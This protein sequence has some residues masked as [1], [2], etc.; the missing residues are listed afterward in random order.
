[1]SMDEIGQELHSYTQRQAAA[2]VR[3]NPYQQADLESMTAGL[4]KA[5]TGMEAGTEF[6]E[7][8]PALGQD[9]LSL[10]GKAMVAAAD[11]PTRIHNIGLDPSSPGYVPLLAGRPTVKIPQGLVDLAPSIAPTIDPE[12]VQGLAQAGK[13]TVESMVP[14][15]APPEV[16][17]T[18][19]LLGGPGAVGK[20]AGTLFGAE[21]L[22][23]VP[24][25]IQQAFAVLMDPNSSRA[26]KAKALAT[27][28]IH[29]ALGALMLRGGM[30]GVRPDAS[31]IREGA[32]QVR[33]AGDVP[34]G[35]Q[36]EGGQE[37]L[38]SPSRSGEQGAPQGE[39][40]PT[41]AALE[42]RARRVWVSSGGAFKRRA[43]KLGADDPIP[44]WED[45]S[46]EQKNAAR[47]AMGMQ[48]A[49]PQAQAATPSEQLA[50][51]TM[52]EVGAKG[53][54]VESDLDPNNA[55]F[56]GQIS[57]ITPDGRIIINRTEFAKW[58]EGIPQAQHAEAI[59]SLIDEEHIHTKTPNAEALD[60]WNSLSALE[61]GLVRRR[62][63]GRW[64]AGR[65]TDS[66]LGHEALRGRLQQ[67]SG[68][69]PREVAEAA[70]RERWTVKGIYAA[71]R[72]IA[73][74]R[75]AL[76]T[77]AS[78]RQTE[79]I[80]RIQG[81]LAVARQSIGAAPEAFRKGSEPKPEDYGD[82]DIRLT[83]F[84][85]GDE[86]VPDIVQAD[87]I[88]GGQNEWSSNPEQLRALGFDIPD[89]SQLPAGRYTLEEAR[90][91]LEQPEAY[92]KKAR[93]Q[94]RGQEMMSLPV[95][96]P[97]EERPGAREAIAQTSPPLTAARI[98]E[99][100][101][102][103]FAESA[104]PNF[105]EF[106][107][108]FPEA[109]PGQLRDAWKDAVWKNLMQAPG[110]LLSRYRDQLGLGKE[111]SGGELPDPV[112]ESGAQAEALTGRR[113]LL[114]QTIRMQKQADRLESEANRMGVDLV[115]AKGEER[116]SLEAEI[117]GRKARAANLRS[118]SEQLAT[119]AQRAGMEA[120]PKVR[121]EMS[122]AVRAEQN[123]RAEAI[124][125]IGYKL[126]NEAEEGQKAWRRN[127]IKPEDV[128]F[129]RST[130]EGALRSISA[131][132][133][134]NPD[135]LARVLTEA[136]G[137]ERSTLR[138]KVS[139]G[140]VIE[141][142]TRAVPES[143]TKRVTALLDKQT[144]RVELVSTYRHGR[145]GTMLV[146]PRAPGKERPN[147]PLANVLG[148]YRPIY[149]VLL[150]EPVQNF[151][152]GFASLKDF[153]DRFAQE[154]TQ[155]EQAQASYEAPRG[156]G[157]PEQQGGVL[158]SLKANPLTDAEAGAVLDHVI[159]ELGEEPKTAED[160]QLAMAGLAEKSTQ[161]I[162]PEF[163]RT[164]AGYQKMYDALRTK[165]KELTPEQALDKLAQEIYEQAQGR[166]DREDFVRQALARG[167][168]ETATAVRPEPEPGT[169]ES[170][171]ARDLTKRERVAPTVVRP[172]Q[173]PPYYKPPAKRPAP[174]VPEGTLEPTKPES[175]EAFRKEAERK[176][177]NMVIKVRG[178]L[179]ALMTRRATK[180]HI[181]ALAD[182]AYTSMA[183]DS[184]RLG[185]S[186]RMQ[187][188]KSM[189]KRA[190]AE[191][192]EAAVAVHASRFRKGELNVFRGKLDNAEQTALRLKSH[193]DPRDK[194]VANMWLT[195]IDRLR[196][197][198]EYA[199]QNWNNTAL[200]N[201]AKAMKQTAKEIHDFDKR[202]GID[203]KP[204]ENYYPGRWEGDVWN[205]DS[206]TFS[207]MDVFG[208]N[209]RGPKTFP[210]IYHAI[211]AGPY[212]PKNFDPADVLEHRARQSRTEI[213]KDM[214]LD[215]L[216]TMEDPRTGTPIIVSPTVRNGKIIA[217]P[218]RVVFR[219]AP[220][221]D[222][223][224]LRKGYSNLMDALTAKSRFRKSTGGRALLKTNA[225]IKHGGL[226]LLDTFHP[227]RLMWYELGLVDKPNPRGSI[228]ALDYRPADLPE[229]VRQ[230]YVTQEAADWATGTV[231]LMDQ[232]SQVQMTRQQLLD[233]GIRHAGLNARRLSDSLYHEIAVFIPGAHRFNKLVF[234]RFAPGLISDAFIRETERMSQAH[235]NMDLNEMSRRV[236]RDLN[237]YFGNIGRQGIFKSETFQDL[238]HLIALAPQWIEG[239]AQKEAR[240]YARTAHAAGQLMTGNRE[241]AHL[242]MG[243]IGRG[244]GRGI[245]A[246]AVL[247]QAVNLITRRQLTFQNKE[248]GHQLDAW[249][250]TGKDQGFWLSPLSIFA[251]LLHDVIRLNQT[252][253][254]VWDAVRQ[255]G[256]NKLSPLARVAWV[257]STGTGPT[258]QIYTSTPRLLGGAASQL[259]PIPITLS[260]PGQYVGHAI[261]PKL[262]PPVPPGQLQR[263]MLAS[264]GGLKVEPS[265]TDLQQMEDKARRFLAVNKLGTP[266]KELVSTDE[267]SYTK[268]RA[269]L[270]NDDQ[271][272]ALRI[273][274]RLR[275]EYHVSDSKIRQ[276]MFS[277]KERPLTGS[278]A[279]DHAFKSSLKP[280]ERDQ[281][282][283]AMQAKDA[284]YK[285]FREWFAE[286]P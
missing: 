205:D 24:E 256:E 110:R 77:D 43:L 17:L 109:K 131:E 34:Q 86:R 239:L 245:L 149:S 162:T 45:L 100:A 259:A 57:T 199:D 157:L 184:H 194:R 76:G 191:L 264:F 269:A 284:Q 159:S 66:Q 42:G 179:A 187:A 214:W 121:T 85:F 103:H 189:G 1:M 144:G 204:V 186:I 265:R 117:Q 59:K 198:V 151:H 261:A 237:F 272:G 73:A 126:I 216:R 165:N 196:Q 111:V 82:K 215:R 218:D 81:N 255:V 270:L 177:E 250:P 104:R 134:K 83:V 247:A 69:S 65:F 147:V 220:Y 238:G 174:P 248:E 258:G 9:I 221:K 172:E 225:L 102:Q 47:V 166:K 12:I 31:R 99:A 16:G 283:R 5:R 232:G 236:A 88:R 2:K 125:S 79:I 94:D 251:E 113:K 260:K 10:P 217:E 26:D 30:E 50:L 95:A 244:M 132:D 114:E 160:V 286:R 279:H 122:G 202:H 257:L 124:S 208:K 123:R 226:L 13:E 241:G 282:D 35:G 207:E 62:Y 167:T 56:A 178:Q 230:G 242:T 175:P 227:V 168:P 36:G 135:T 32:Q 55:P 93:E 39:I 188:P 240:F 6:T 195:A 200:H 139:G 63:T 219:L 197:G 23:N 127:Q 233:Y 89:T 54:I 234:E 128:G 229:A 130:T 276:A 112:P 70:G 212:V 101:T 143:V 64:G 133:L 71:E 78:K 280:E 285:K 148:R 235:P 58:L 140:K 228:A 87:G 274:K 273:Y 84:R 170:P 3:P 90:K 105:K 155:A 44:A 266:G 48:P 138:R 268:I 29:G 33:P 27:P 263:Q 176:S 107:G 169:A 158:E 253:P 150:D 20:I 153:N 262:V 281:Y 61:K 19:P 97:G 180:E 181:A 108:Q 193:L 249:I 254:K 224:M 277:W 145:S 49:A 37:L 72:A 68:M 15:F 271:A 80:D 21:Q 22:V 137:V 213:Y 183:E 75:E 60:Y 173:T 53:D 96:A 267:P 92:R 203:L 141:T 246:M 211:E 252:K 120:L 161:A 129:W 38:V 210:T 67:L 275:D 164:V 106:A 152:Q 278:A 91:A 223:V 231:T 156:E 142:H 118:R 136:A 171:T 52:E 192:R 11:V 7:A 119:M 206:I 8:L 116:L 25:E 46:A 14:P 209:F 18:L 41:D 115:I 201:T 28:G 51:D 185:N 243:T 154:A 74:V 4:G 163:R 222:A 182:S 190:A 98:D 146:D 40:A